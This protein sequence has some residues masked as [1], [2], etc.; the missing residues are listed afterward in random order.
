M[1][2]LNLTTPEFVNGRPRWFD[3]LGQPRDLSDTAWVMS[4]SSAI[5]SRPLVSRLPIT[6]IPGFGANDRGVQSFDDAF[7]AF[8]Q[9]TIDDCNDQMPKDVDPRGYVGPSGIHDSFDRCLAVAGYSMNPMSMAPIDNAAFVESLGLPISD[10]RSARHKKIFHSFFRRL[11][12]SWKRSS[13]KTAK[14]STSGAPVWLPNAQHKREHALYLLSQHERVV[15]R[16]RARNMLS[17][18]GEDK[19][20]FLFNAGRRDQVDAIGKERLVFPLEYALSGGRKG[21]PIVADKRVI[22][23]GRTYER[24]SAVRARLFHG[25]PYA[26]NFYPQIIATGTL[27]AMFENYAP[28][29]HCSDV[30]KLAEGILPSEEVIC[31]DATEY[32][33]S[34][35]TFLIKEMFNVMREFWNDDWVDWSEHLAFSAYYTRPVSMAKSG[36][37]SKPQRVGNPYCPEH[38]V[39]K[40]N[41]SGHAMTSFI[42]KSMMVFDFLATADDITGNVDERMDDYLL[43]KMPLKTH[44]NGDDG[45][46]RGE[47][48]LV[49][50]YAQ[51]R[52]GEKNPGYFVLKPEQGH[53]WSGYIMAPQPEGGY[54]A[55]HRVH[56][57]LEKLFCPERSAGSRF[58]PRWTI[59]FLQRLNTGTNPSHSRLIEIIAKNWRDYAAPHYGDLM[60]M[61]TRHHERLEFNTAALTPADREVLEDITKYYSRGYTEEDISPQVMAMLFEQAISAEEVEPV[62]TSIFSGNII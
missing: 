52:F 9:Q 29:F 25:A 48:A 20:V 12:S 35:A 10:F 59:G 8:Y 13:I 7:L 49:R 41:P 54:R 15:R 62:V 42:A 61:I 51:H 33:R 22:I 56:T 17:L 32:D 45:M 19:V 43:H 53:V 21:A 40:G 28:T 44:N 24:F 26:A 11:F 34:M 38:Q 4:D 39:F 14:L 57:T 47:R 2:T 31:S 60:E 23:E 16:F 36:P 55:Y 5:H 37:E 18:A 46:Y 58:R 27:H 6:I 50:R 30:P 1:T 3:L